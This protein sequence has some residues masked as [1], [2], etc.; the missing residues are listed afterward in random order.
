MG[1]SHMM[2]SGYLLGNQSLQRLISL[3]IGVTKIG[4]ECGLREKDGSP[5]RQQLFELPWETEQDS[6]YMKGHEDKR[7]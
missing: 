1:F 6:H 4:T 5:S 7:E 2:A 3:K